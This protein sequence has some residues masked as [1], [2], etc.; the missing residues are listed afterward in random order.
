VA[1]SL[2]KRFPKLVT[3]KSREHGICGLESIAQRPFA[4]LSGAKLTWWQRKIYSLTHVSVDSL[5]NHGTQDDNQTSSRWSEHNERDEENLLET[6]G[7]QVLVGNNTSRSSTIM[8]SN[9][10][11]G[12]LTMLASVNRIPNITQ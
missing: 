12:I 5:S 4:F 2:V 3:E 8:N 1:R 7:T 11:K 10:T 6:E 9:I